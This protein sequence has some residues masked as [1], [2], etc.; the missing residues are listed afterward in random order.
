[1]NENLV[2]LQK[3]IDELNEE[4]HLTIVQ[5]GYS[6]FITINNQKYLCQNCKKYTR[7]ICTETDEEI[8]ENCIVCNFDKTQEVYDE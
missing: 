7:T 8:L 3:N 4:I 2:Q 6:D 5:K 1:M